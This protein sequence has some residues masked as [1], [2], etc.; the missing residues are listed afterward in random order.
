MKLKYQLVFLLLLGITV[1]HC[2]GMT[3]LSSLP[4]LAIQ[5]K[6]PQKKGWGSLIGRNWFAG[7]PREGWST[8]QSYTIDPLKKGLTG[9]Q[10]ALQKGAVSTQE[11]LQKSWQD[12]QKYIP[13]VN[14][15][16]S[17]KSENKELTKENEKLKKGLQD[18]FHEKLT[19]LRLQLEYSPDEA[20]TTDINREIQET[21]EKLEQLIPKSFTVFG[22]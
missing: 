11:A 5:P 22:Y 8:L 21:E 17:L 3:Q 4:S 13:L 2:A 19:K 12:T 10:E 20:T 18:V 16:N 7:A 6:S 14:T 9:A 1:H 15:I